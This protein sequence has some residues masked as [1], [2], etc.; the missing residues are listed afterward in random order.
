MPHVGTLT[1]LYGI[2]RPTI[3]E[4]EKYPHLEIIQE[5]LTM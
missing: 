1:S 4:I 3:I 2:L 5:Q